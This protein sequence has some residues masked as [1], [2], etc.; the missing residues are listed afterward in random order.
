MINVLLV[1][2][3]DH[4]YGSAKAAMNLIKLAAKHREEINYVVLTQTRGEINTL[5][6]DLHIRNYVT[7]HAYGVYAPMGSPLLSFVK[8]SI[9]KQVVSH[10]NR[11]AVAKTEQLIDFSQIDIIHTNIDR[12]VIGCILSEKYHLPHIM[13]L[14]EFARGHY[15]CDPLY[16]N[17]YKWYNKSTDRYI[18][19]SKA[20]GNNWNEV[21]L[22]DEK[23][24]VIY[25]GINA[26]R[27][28]PRN[29]QKEDG[30][31]RIV[32]CGDISSLKGQDQTVKALARLKN[33]N[34]GKIITLDIYGEVHNEKEYLAE[35]QEYINRNNLSDTVFFRGYT[36]K[37]PEV[38]QHYDCG[39]I[40]SK[41][42]GFGL[43]TAEFMAAGLGVIASD[44]GASP[45]LIEDNKS[46]LLYHYGDIAD[47][48]D[49]INLLVE[50]EELCRSFGEE[51]RKKVLSTFTAE[52]NFSG[53]MNLY[54]EV[55]KESKHVK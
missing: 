24:T 55:L 6:D 44:T 27:V 12:D 46:G 20:V 51:A 38:L 9:K 5:C 4:Q 16:K 47:L 52:N 41:R 15:N 11:K 18:A 39:I 40:C 13:H 28:I 36:N 26:D 48:T 3:M 17:Q 43:S 29:P 14:R 2:G 45:E 7:G 8:K 1:C 34:P 33:N 10:K 32:M 42:E 22:D 31:F 50:N 35:M 37:L 49:K 30:T 19:I 53:V 54:S 21:G 23:I 25:D